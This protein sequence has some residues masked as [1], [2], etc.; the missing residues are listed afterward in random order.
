[1]PNAS[2][3]PTW[4]ITTTKSALAMASR[5]LVVAQTLAGN[6][7]SLIIRPTNASIR[8]SLV[9]VGD[10]SANSLSCKRGRG[11][12]V[13]DQ[14]LAEHHAAGTDHGDFPGHW[15]LLSWDGHYSV[16]RK[17]CLIFY[18][19]RP[20]PR[21]RRRTRAKLRDHTFLRQTSDFIG[22]NGMEASDNHFALVRNNVV[23]VQNHVQKEK[24]N[25]ILNRKNIEMNRRIIEKSQKHF[26]FNAPQRCF[27][28]EQ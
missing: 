9:S 11:E 3:P 1:M 18:R 6:L 28:S 10:I 13:G 16:R 8:R 20:I 7:L 15:A 19:S 22:S 4:I 21:E 5:R 24:Y 26:D 2:C 23:N 25:I 14:R 27:G 17:S 12:N